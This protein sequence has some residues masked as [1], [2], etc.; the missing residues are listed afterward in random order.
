MARSVPDISSRAGRQTARQ[1]RTL[2][3]SSIPDI[4][5]LS[6]ANPGS[7][8]AYVSTGPRIARAYASSTSQYQR[9]HGASL[10]K[11]RTSCSRSLCQDWTMRRAILC[12]FQTWRC[13][14]WGC[15]LLRLRVP[16][17]SLVAAYATSV[18]DMA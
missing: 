9:E 8:I 2:H 6:N 17:G 7:S 11:D 1:Y 4:A 14:L 18:P 5:D 13:P 10:Y 3:T 12:Q 15:Y 16:V